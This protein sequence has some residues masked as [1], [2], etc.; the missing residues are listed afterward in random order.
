MF[1]RH[2]KQ[3]NSKT[4]VHIKYRTFYSHPY[5]SWRNSVNLTPFTLSLIMITIYISNNNIKK[6]IT[7]TYQGIY[8][9]FK[10]NRTTYKCP[11]KVYNLI[12]NIA[13][14]NSTL[15]N[16]HMFSYFHVF[17]IFLK[18]TEEIGKRTYPRKSQTPCDRILC[19][20]QPVKVFSSKLTKKI[21]LLFLLTMSRKQ[22]PT[23]ILHSY[24]SIA[25]DN[26]NSQWC[27]LSQKKKNNF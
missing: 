26:W 4:K 12:N 25:S 2:K 20:F 6:S 3:L 21:K 10:Y 27:H 18:T 9:F 17:V 5:Y 22:N 8:L 23:P 11:Q 7:K 13:K 24:A 1:L 14:I 16:L 19:L 15:L